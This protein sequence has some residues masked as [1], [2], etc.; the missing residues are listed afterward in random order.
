MSTNPVRATVDF[1][2][3][4]HARQVDFLTE[5]D[6]PKIICLCGSTR[7][8]VTWATARY[9]LTLAGAIVLLAVGVGLG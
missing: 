9:D 8:P 4:V 2:P 5:P 1:D 3:V 7:F 6:R